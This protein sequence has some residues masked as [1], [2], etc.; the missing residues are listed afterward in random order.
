MVLLNLLKVEIHSIAFK[1]N[2]FG[3]ETIVKS[4]DYQITKYGR[5]IPLV[6]CEPVIIN[7]ASVS[8]ITGNNFKVYCR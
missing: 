7:G 8:N 5:L 1:V 4:V 3:E 6:R 2:S